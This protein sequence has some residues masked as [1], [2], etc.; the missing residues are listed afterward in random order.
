[1]LRICWETTGAMHPSLLK[2]MAELSLKSGGVI[3][4]DLKAWDE[5]I[6]IALCGVTN[7]R[8]L[9]NFRYLSGLIKER[10]DVPLL[11]ASTLLVP[12][13]IDEIE[14]QGIARFI[15]AIDPE[16]PFTLLGFY[17]QFYLKDLPPTSRHH[18]EKCLRIA[19]KAGLKNVRV[20]NENLLS[21]A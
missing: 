8:T 17:P 12:G 15:A 13:Y 16:I 21:N 18:A 9:E 20:G 7:Q 4:F 6:H 1:M 10:P 11:A 2:K 19:Q 3:K 5:N 14:V